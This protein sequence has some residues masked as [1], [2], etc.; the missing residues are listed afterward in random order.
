M[1]KCNAL[2]N[3]ILEQIQLGNKWRSILLSSMP[4]TPCLCFFKDHT[5]ALPMAKLFSK[6]A[7]CCNPSSLYYPSQHSLHFSS[8]PVHGWLNSARTFLLFFLPFGCKLLVKLLGDLPCNW[9]ESSFSAWLCPLVGNRVYWPGLGS[10]GK[11]ETGQESFPP[12]LDHQKRC[13]G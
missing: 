9:E 8:L 7:C 5:W 1:K 13:A 3:L 2:F 11:E 6:V 4:V 10:Q 12:L